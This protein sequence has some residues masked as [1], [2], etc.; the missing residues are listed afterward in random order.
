[1]YVNHKNQDIQSKL[2]IMANPL[3]IALPFIAGICLNETISQTS[4]HPSSI[5]CET[6]YIDVIVLTQ[7]IQQA[8]VFKDIKDDII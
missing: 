1:M 6:R 2:T 8:I 3:Y 4:C 7:G 5:F